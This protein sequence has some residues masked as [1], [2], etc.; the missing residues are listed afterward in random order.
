M[1]VVHLQLAAGAAKFSCRFSPILIEQHVLQDQASL[2]AKKDVEQGALVLLVSTH[3]KPD[4]TP[5]TSFSTKPGF[6]NMGFMLVPNADGKTSSLFISYIPGNTHG[7]ADGHVADMVRDWLHSNQLNT[8]YC[9]NHFG[10]NTYK[11]DILSLRPAIADPTTP[12]S[13]VA[14]RDPNS[15]N[16]PYPCLVVELEF[17]NRNAEKPNLFISLFFGIKIWKKTQNDGFAAVAILWEKILPLRVLHC[18]I[19]LILAP[20]QQI[21]KNE[22]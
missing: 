20:E 14:D 9:K 4:W 6:R 15:S 16:F 3:V 13:G 21:T 17:C 5:P 12:H 11:P 22:G 18:S 8:L 1:Q 7:E 19:L 2:C 10:G